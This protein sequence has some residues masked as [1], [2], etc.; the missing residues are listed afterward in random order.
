MSCE[1]TIATSNDNPS[2]SDN[3]SSK[4]NKSGQSTTNNSPK[5]R[6][7]KVVLFKLN[8]GECFP[9]PG[10]SGFSVE[11]PITAINFGMNRVPGVQQSI[12]R[13]SKRISEA[14]A[15]CCLGCESGDSC[16]KKGPENSKSS[17]HR[18]KDAT[19]KRKYVYTK[20]PGRRPKQLTQTT[21]PK[22]QSGTGLRVV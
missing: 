7:L 18:V 3:V 2:L 13:R 22:S 1:A 16:T 21:K 5:L 14:A 15:T 10:K 19:K 4:Q 17:S 12:Q 20:K 6:D 8:V 11:Y 9:L